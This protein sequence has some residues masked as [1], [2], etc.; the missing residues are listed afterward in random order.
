MC[1]FFQ[2]CLLRPNM[3]IDPHWYCDGA[4]VGKILDHESRLEQKLE[5]FEN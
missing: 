5:L 2:K 3:S 4:S 1:R